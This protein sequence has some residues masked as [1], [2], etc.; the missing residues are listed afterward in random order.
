MS[1]LTF[2]LYI[3]FGFIFGWMGGANWIQQQWLHCAKNN[4]VMRIRKKYYFEV[5]QISEEEV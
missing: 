4:I 5:K 2:L 3:L 1:E